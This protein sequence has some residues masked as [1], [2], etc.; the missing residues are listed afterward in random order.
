MTLTGQ[1]IFDK[2]IIQGGATDRIRDAS[3]DLGLDKM[4]HAGS[5]KNGP[6]FTIEPQQMVILLSSETVKIPL[7][8]VGIATLKTGLSFRGILSLNQGLIDPGFEGR[9][10]SSAINFQEKPVQLKQGDTFLR[11]VIHKLTQEV[12]TALKV[13][14]DEYTKEK[15]RESC[16]YP[17]SFL[18]LP[19]QIEDISNKVVAKETKQYMS[20]LTKIT[21][22]V[23][24]FAVFFAIYALVLPPLQ[25]WLMAPT[26]TDQNTK[27]EAM[28]NDL[29]EMKT[30]LENVLTAREEETVSEQDKK[31][32]NIA[33]DIREVQKKLDSLILKK[34]KKHSTKDSKAPN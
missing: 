2:G 3:Y 30:K 10:S 21:V 27:I 13:S 12:G 34:P 20:L 17:E 23:G 9:I 18:N 22:V 25:Q 14:D 4:I 26:H 11:I 1:E 24:F 32:N 7:G 29:S 6:I 16:L 31:I 5:E 33:S 8:Y 15:L 19:K 28:A